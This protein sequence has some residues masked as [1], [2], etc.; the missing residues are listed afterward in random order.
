M[1]E[2][3]PSMPVQFGVNVCVWVCVSGQAPR[4]SQ[5]IFIYDGSFLLRCVW[6]SGHIFRLAKF[7]Q[8]NFRHSRTYLSNKK[9]GIRK[10]SCSA[11]AKE[12]S[13]GTK[14]KKKKRKKKERKR[15]NKKIRGKNVLKWIVWE[16]EDTKNVCFSVCAPRRWADSTSSCTGQIARQ[17]CSEQIIVDI[18][19]RNQM[20]N[21]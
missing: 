15:K 9:V 2:N 20:E 1:F 12:C 4:F 16:F 13:N 11:R 6:V 5:F 21:W 17:L 14:L 8:T 19:T 18:I 10:V 7:T 3:A